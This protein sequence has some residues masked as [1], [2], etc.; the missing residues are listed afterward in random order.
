MISQRSWQVPSRIKQD[1]SRIMAG[2]LKDHGRFSQGSCQDHSMNMSGLIKDHGWISQESWQDY[3]RIM[4]GSLKDHVKILFRNVSK[5]VLFN[6]SY[7]NH[8]RT[9]LK[10]LQDILK[11]VDMSSCLHPDSAL[12][13]YLFH[14]ALDSA[15]YTRHHA[16][17]LVDVISRMN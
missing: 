12:S 7:Q 14:C 10:F 11:M 5:F 16:L 6:I 9:F 15:F 8:A 3:S 17:D 4:A 1:L 13:S 2:S